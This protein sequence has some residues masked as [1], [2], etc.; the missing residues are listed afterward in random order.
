MKLLAHKTVVLKL[1][2]HPASKQKQNL[3]YFT[4]S[5]F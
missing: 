2:S 5:Y 4:D 1:Q 3:V